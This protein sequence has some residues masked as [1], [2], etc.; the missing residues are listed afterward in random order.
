MSSDP[1]SVIYTLL[2]LGA[3]VYF[4]N[5]FWP[6][7]HS[8]P[9]IPAIGPSAPLLSYYGALKFIYQG[10]EMM[11]EG[12]N[13][14]KGSVFK[15]PQL[16]RW[17]VIVTAPKL[18][19]EI[20][21]AGDDELNFLDAAIDGL[22]T[23]YTMGTAISNNPYHVPIIRSQLTRNLSTL[24]SDIRDEL[25]TA[26]K[27]FIPPTDEWTKVTALPTVMQIVCRTSNRIFVGQP[28]CR[29]PDY[30]NLN[31]TYTV[32][33][34]KAGLTIKMFPRLLRPLVAL[35]LTNISAN[36]NRGIKHLGPIIKERFEKMAEYGDD[37]EG[38]PNDML[39]WIMEVAEG[40]EREIPALVQRILAINFAAIH[41]SSM[42]FAHALYHLAQN[43][44]YALPL[45]QEVESV[46]AEEGWTKN[47]M[48]KMRKVD[49]FLRECQRYHSLGLV[50]MTRR[51][52]KDFQFSDGTFIPAGGFVSAAT[53]TIHHDNEYYSDPDLFDPWRFADL[54]EEEGEGLKHQMVSTSLDPGRFFAANE[55]KGMLAHLVMTYDVKLPPEHERV[56]NT[57]SFEF[58]H[59]P[60]PSVEI[61]FRKRR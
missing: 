28:V 37:W 1:P 12:Y 34:V 14:Y 58:N 54:R 18:V 35:F 13:R 19:D 44:E 59:M 17:H 2:A 52:V 33:V 8:L 31:I 27:D 55:L 53:M 42:S 16:F 5:W 11:Q 45:R 40:E 39:M 21:R 61:L 41:T 26:F 9:G 60:N 29:D 38:K 24:F 30:A 3:A 23:D 51:A 56:P 10:R 48:Q 22:Q 25:S 15:L 36:I 4:V 6:S 7:K 49:S 46:V 20:R 50:S 47:A 32:D 57:L 43:P